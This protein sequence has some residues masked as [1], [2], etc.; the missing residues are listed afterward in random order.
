MLDKLLQ[1]AEEL[2]ANFIS[3]EKEYG[4]RNSDVDSG[5]WYSLSY[6]QAGLIKKLKTF[7]ESNGWV[8]Y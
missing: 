8:P 1:Q 5:E 7:I 3:T 6:K 2:G 4:Q